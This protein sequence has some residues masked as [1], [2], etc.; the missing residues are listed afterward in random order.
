M[1]L[2]LND[3]TLL[4]L[5]VLAVVVVA[6][7]AYFL[8]VGPLLNRVGDRAEERDAK[9]AQL[10]Q[11]SA[12]VRDLER[13]QQNAGNLGQRLLELN[14]RVPEEPEIPTLLVQ[15]QEIATLSNVTQ[16]RI[17]PGT[18]GPPPAGGTYSIVPLTMSFQ[19]TYEDLRDFLLRSNDLARLVT[20]NGV[21]YEP[22]D[23]AVGEEDLSEVGVEQVLNV[24]IE[25]EVYFQPQGTTSDGSTPLPED[26][27]I[28]PETTVT[29]EAT[30]EP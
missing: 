29:G 15:M 24:E 12:Q 19:G 17:E 30:V 16:I 4:L 9:Q 11:V 20:V 6:L 10:D 26:S 25:A 3:R 7:I 8:V 27:N 2:N 23:P 5:S 21:S 13:V 18:P 14:K 22:V 1:N 28:S